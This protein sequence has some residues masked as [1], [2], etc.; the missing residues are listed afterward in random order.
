MKCESYQVVLEHVETADLVTHV[1][2]NVMSVKWRY[3]LFK[4]TVHF[5]S[6]SSPIRRDSSVNSE[7]AALRGC[8]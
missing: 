3:G 6:Y 7:Y 1:N 4:V 8:F 2:P 5:I